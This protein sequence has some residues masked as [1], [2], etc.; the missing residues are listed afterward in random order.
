MNSAPAPDVRVE[1][2]PAVEAAS[3]PASLEEFAE[4]GGKPTNPWRKRLSFALKAAVSLGL[5]VWIVSG[6]D[7]AEVAE[8]AKG[9]HVGWLAFAASLQLVGPWLTAWRWKGV[10][11]SRGFRPSMGYLYRSCLVAVF[12][13]QFMP[14]ILGG[15]TIRGYDA[16]KAG[17][18]KGLA[19]TSVVVDRL[20]GLVALASFAVVALAFLHGPLIERVPG[21]RLWAAA[22]LLGTMGMTWAMFARNEKIHARLAWAIGKLPAL[23]G[24]KV[25][26][27][28]EALSGYRGQTN[29]M[30]VAFAISVLLQL[31]V[32][33]F[34][35]AIGMALGL[36]IGFA[37]WFVI[38]PVAIFIMLA[39]IS[40]NGVGL[41]ES[42][43][44][45]L[46]A[47]VFT[48]SR[49]EALAFAWIEYGIFLF[50]GLVG[51]LV[52]MLRPPPEVSAAASGAAETSVRQVP[53]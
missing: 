37:N 2:A 46:L 53:G 45:F 9:V 1:P 50:F 28:Y 34:Y 26:K 6:A 31:K 23:V 47:T 3:R 19:V 25:G 15:D 16:W 35:Y 14:S 39:P 29:A 24:R 12:F 51:G 33:L 20:I 43:F 18:G 30:A 52:Y 17:A 10:L 48:A 44:T 42:V 27:V 41:R 36:E 4:A 38:V 7:L 49:S 5:I 22:A 32:V 13:K 11:A 21:V 40:I 8:A